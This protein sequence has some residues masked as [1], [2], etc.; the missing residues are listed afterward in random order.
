M[1]EPLVHVV[2]GF[3]TQR[4][5]AR[6]DAFVA[7]GQR[8]ADIEFGRVELV[9]GVAR[10]VAQLRHVVEVE[11][12]LGHLQAVRRVDFVDPEQVRFGADER[13]QRHHQ[14]LADRDRSADW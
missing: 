3:G 7:P 12:R 10:D 5:Q 4:S 11:D 14:L 6:F 2:L 8:I 1:L 9:A 13:N